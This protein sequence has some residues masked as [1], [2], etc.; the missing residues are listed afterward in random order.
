MNWF[1][2]AHNVVPHSW[3]IKSLELVGPAKNIVNLLKETMKDWKIN[4]ICSNID[5][6][7]VK[8]NRRTFQGGSL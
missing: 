8:I 4:L 1:Q 3:M 6:G 7:A 2:E 5:L